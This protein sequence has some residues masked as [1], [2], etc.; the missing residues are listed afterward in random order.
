MRWLLLLIGMWTGMS[1]DAHA[2]T[3]SGGERNYEK[4]MYED[5]RRFLKELSR[6]IEARGFRHVEIIP[7][8]FVAKAKGPD[9]VERTLIINSDT[10]NAFSFDGPLPLPERG[11]VPETRLPALH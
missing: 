1:F 6:L 8:L 3:D 7:Q 4:T 9:G 5:N 10:L 2:A 11:A